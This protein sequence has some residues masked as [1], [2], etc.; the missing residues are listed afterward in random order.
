MAVGDAVVNNSSIA[1]AAFL[2]IQPG[3]GV[4]W[5]VHNIHH[6]AN[7]EVSWYDGTNTI[8]TEAYTGAG[9]RPMGVKVTN[10][11]RLRI[12]NTDAATKRI[13]YDAVVTK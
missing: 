13:G 1:A 4:E 8:T 6:E 11:I 5:W 10:S 7:I 9:R 3:S 12:K 2:D